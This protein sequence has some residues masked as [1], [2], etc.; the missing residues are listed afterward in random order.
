MLH[1]SLASRQQPFPTQSTTDRRPENDPVCPM[2]DTDNY[3]SDN[4]LDAP[5]NQLLRDLIRYSGC[6]P[7]SIH[8]G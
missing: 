8:L 7:S 6:T 3:S 4:L 2:L 1:I 5:P